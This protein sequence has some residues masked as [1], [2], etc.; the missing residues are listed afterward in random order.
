MTEDKTIK[1]VIGMAAVVLIAYFMF[2]GGQVPGSTPVTLPGTTQP[3]SP[4]VITVPAAP[5][6]AVTATG[7]LSLKPLSSG[8]SAGT[9]SSMLML[10]ESNAVYNN[11]VFDERATRYKIMKQIADYDIGTLKS[12]NG[13]QPAVLSASSGAWSQTITAKVGDKLVAY[14]YAD[15]TPASGENASTA[16]LITITDFNRA[17][18]NFFAVTNDGKPTWDLYNYATYN[19][20]DTT[21]TKR[22]NYTIGDGGSAL[23]SQT[24]TW[25]S[26]STAVGQGCFD[27]AI[28]MI[29]DKNYTA[30]FKDITITARAVKNGAT[31]SVK[32]STPR[33][34]STDLA[35][36]VLPATTVSQEVYFIGYIPDGFDTVR[37]SVDKN[38][39]TWTLTTDTYGTDETVTFY[40]VENSH[41]LGTTNGIFKQADPMVVQLSNGGST[42]FNVAI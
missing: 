23:V 24:A 5:A 37:T 3:T 36:S 9:T 6:S 19:F 32:F 7:T 4:T 39:L 34:A 27:C 41:A 25:Y 16:K 29:S 26:N 12:F 13:G 22:D 21:F 17:T 42:G 11:G 30:K 31:S 35:A 10:A 33:V 20:S 1:F 8:G 28:Y 2:G 40:I 38:H 18:E 14:T 15:S